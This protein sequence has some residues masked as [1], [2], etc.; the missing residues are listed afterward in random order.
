MN[1]NRTM[2]GLRRAHRGRPER[3]QAP[4]ITRAVIGSARTGC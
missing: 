3:A 4:A 2:G 1:R